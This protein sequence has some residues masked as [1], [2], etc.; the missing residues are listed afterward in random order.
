[1][2]NHRVWSCF[3]ASVLVFVAMDIWMDRSFG[4]PRR[5]SEDVQEDIHRNLSE[6]G[7]PDIVVTVAEDGGDFSVTLTGTVAEARDIGRVASIAEG[8]QSVAKPVDNRVSVARAERTPEIVRN[9]VQQALAQ[10]GYRQIRVIVDSTFSVSL[11][12]TV[13]ERHDMNQVVSI[14][15]GIPSVKAVANKITVA[16]RPPKPRPPPPPEPRGPIVLVNRT[17]RRIEYSLKRQ[18]TQE[19]I[20]GGSIE[21]GSSTAPIYAPVGQYLVFYRLE[22]N[23]SLMKKDIQLENPRL[24]IDV[25]LRK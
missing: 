12:G 2:V 16:P 15:E 11:A 9:E 21:A 17:S 18:S 4:L 1:M 10:A 22:G 24:G 6:E 5:S 13:P 25:Q 19:D 7:F 20:S 8:I 14:A 23:E 3:I